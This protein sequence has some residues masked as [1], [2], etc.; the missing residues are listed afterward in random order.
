MIHAHHRPFALLT[1]DG[2]GYRFFPKL[3]G[4][5]AVAILNAGFSDFWKDLPQGGLLL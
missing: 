5:T 1:Q 2:R 3:S 4:T